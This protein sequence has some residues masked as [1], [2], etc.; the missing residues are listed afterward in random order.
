MSSDSRHDETSHPISD[1]FDHMMAIWEEM[2]LTLRAASADTESQLRQTQLVA[3]SIE[4]FIQKHAEPIYRT[5]IER[6]AD[7]DPLQIELTYGFWVSQILLLRCDQ[8]NEQS[9]DKMIEFT[10]SCVR[11]I[12]EVG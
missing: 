9:Q 3:N 6:I 4:G 8:D 5:Y 12:V 7:I 1:A 2:Y 10:R 11:P